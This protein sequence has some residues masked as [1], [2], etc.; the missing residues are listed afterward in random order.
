MSSVVPVLFIDVLFGC[1]GD[2]YSNRIFFALVHARL[3][4]Q[5]VC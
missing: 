2:S 4:R 3:V 1:L 5:T